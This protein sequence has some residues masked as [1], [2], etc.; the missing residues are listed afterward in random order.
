MPE[1]YASQRQ[2]QRNGRLDKILPAKFEKFRADKTR[3]VGPCGQADYQHYVEQTPWEERDDCDDE[4][5]NGDSHH[6]FNEP[7]TEEVGFAARIAKYRPDYDSND[8]RYAD[9]NET[10]GQRDSAAVYKPTENVGTDVVGAEPVLPVRRLLADLQIGPAKAI[11]HRRKDRTGRLARSNHRFVI[12]GVE[13]ARYENKQEYNANE[14]YK[15][16]Y[17]NLPP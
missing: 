1:E 7:H 5:K 15:N 16:A 10:D 8:A 13:A 11:R 6:N 2:P 14:H 17:G 4:E 3:I 12:S 9:G